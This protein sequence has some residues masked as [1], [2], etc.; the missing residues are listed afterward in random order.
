LQ[1]GRPK[2]P[3]VSEGINSATTYNI[4]DVSRSVIDDLTI[5]N[6]KLK[7]RLRKYE[8][9]YSPYLEEDMLFEV[10]IHG[11]PCGKKRELEET[12]RVFTA[13]MDCKPPEG[14]VPSPSQDVQQHAFGD[15]SQPATS[16]TSNLRPI[17]SAYVSMSNSG[18]TS[19]SA[20]SHMKP[21]QR[22]V[23]QPMDLKEQKVQPFPRN[24]PDGLFPEYPTVM[25]E[26]QKKEAVVRRLEQ[27]FTGN[28]VG[29][30]D[31]HSQ[32]IQQQELFQ[33]AAYADQTSK[34]GLT[35]EGRREAHI[36]PYE[37]KED[38]LRC[39]REAEYS[40]N[41]TQSPGMPFDLAMGKNSDVSFPEQRPTRLL[42]LDPDRPQIPSDNLRYIRHL[43]LS[44]TREDAPGG[45]TNSSG[46]IYL[47]LLINMAQLHL[48]NVTPNF[49]RS[50]ITDM[51]DK[52]ELSPDG[53]KIRWRGGHEGTRLST[54]SHSSSVRNHTP[55][56]D[57]DSTDELYTKRRRID[58]GR[59]TSAH[60]DI[61]LPTSLLEVTNVFH[62]YKPLFHHPGSS[63]G[64]WTLF[65]ESEPPFERGIGDD[66]GSRSEPRRAGQG[67]DGPIIFY[68]GARFYTDLSGDRGSIDAPPRV[69][70]VGRDRYSDHTQDAVGYDAKDQTLPLSRTS[71]GSSFPFRPF[72]DCSRGT[73]FLD[74]GGSGAKTPDLLS[75]D[76]MT[77]K[78][79]LKWSEDQNSPDMPL[80]AFS[81]SGLGGIQP[82]DHFVMKV[83][84]RRPI[85]D[86]YNQTKLSGLPASGP[87]SGKPLHAMSNVFLDSIRESEGSNSLKRIP[88]SLAFP[89]AFQP[90]SHVTN[91]FPVNVEFISTKF[92]QLEPSALPAP[93]G[94]YAA[95][96]DDGLDAS[97]SSSSG[98][99]PLRRS[100]S[101]RQRS[102]SFISDHIHHLHRDQEFTSK[103]I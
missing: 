39:G 45:T 30:V 29:S 87:A 28:T 8:A 23:S 55:Q 4:S 74:A 31:E 92:T 96:S 93:S 16:S 43:G 56:D 47:N 85:L 9:S 83:E 38:V 7:E 40:S 34:G 69:P 32:T 33:S 36:L 67:N 84:T 73:G 81:A 63:S 3:I 95:S 14:K 68:R 72:R 50:A 51:S 71:S 58:V 77:M 54:G 62:H 11:L 65:D 22:V 44:D 80:Q 6:Q 91:K 25:S 10:K 75:E 57:S 41:E 78:F 53:K 82:A 24:I 103:R 49:V 88:P 76:P 20:I 17:D 79:A 100:R 64:E 86:E 37:I 26:L 101:F 18:P 27:L 52:F 2:D 46:W 70:G 5:E 15:T 89:N 66:R 61:P 102:S 60:I 19:T 98:F 35:F 90:S 48:I 13:S 99:S 59:F 1:S 97:G 94:Y 21:D 42:D 12:L